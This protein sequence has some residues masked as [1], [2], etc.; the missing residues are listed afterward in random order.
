MYNYNAKCVK[1]VD[2]D[3]IDAMIDLGFVYTLKKK[4]DLL[5]LMHQN[6]EQ[7][8]KLEKKIKVWLQKEKANRYV[9][10]CG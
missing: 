6:L 4:L 1:V 5:V 2:G 3:T 9:R 10:W 8:I 7:E